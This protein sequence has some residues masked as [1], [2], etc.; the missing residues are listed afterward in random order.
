MTS[1]VELYDDT[2]SLVGSISWLHGILQQM[3]LTEATPLLEQGFTGESLDIGPLTQWIYVLE[4]RKKAAITAGPMGSDDRE[5]RAYADCVWYL[6]RQVSS[7][8]RFVSEM[9]F[10]WSAVWV[11]KGLETWQLQ[12]GLA[13][14]ILDLY[15][16]RRDEFA[17]AVWDGIRSLPPRD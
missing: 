1:S 13:M 11:Q 10:G 17:Q 8:A 16:G 14:K 7:D 3:L 12:Y 15:E 9:D 6:A 4:T 2:I 5:I